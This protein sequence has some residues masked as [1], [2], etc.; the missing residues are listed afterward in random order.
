M[1]ELGNDGCLITGSLCSDADLTSD[2]TDE[3]IILQRDPISSL[4]NCL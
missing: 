4:Y 2:F 1:D 3:D